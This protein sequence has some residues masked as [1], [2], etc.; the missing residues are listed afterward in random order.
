VPRPADVTA[1]ERRAAQDALSEL[2]AT[3][4]GIAHLQEAALCGA[5]LGSRL[6]AA[7]CPDDLSD[8]ICFANG[9]RCA[10]S[11]D[12]W[13]P[14]VNA[15]KRYAAGEYDTPGPELA[16]RLARGEDPAG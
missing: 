5:W 15:L 11:A 2:P 3:I 10:M 16:E 7:G 4:A 14:T 13:V 1:E 9:Q 12:P 8:R 6:R